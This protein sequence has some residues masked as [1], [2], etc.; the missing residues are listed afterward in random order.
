MWLS[1]SIYRLFMHSNGSVWIYF[2]NWQCHIVGLS[3]FLLLFFRPSSMFLW[4]VVRR[5]K[6]IKFYVFCSKRRRTNI[7][8][9]SNV[10]SQSPDIGRVVLSDLNNGSGPYHSSS[11]NGIPESKH[12]LCH[13]KFVC[14]G[15]S[16]PVKRCQ[17]V[18]ISDSPS[19]SSEFK[20]CPLNLYIKPTISLCGSVSWH[21]W[22]LSNIDTLQHESITLLYIAVH[23]RPTNNVLISVHQPYRHCVCVLFY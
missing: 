23:T 3:S 12:Y 15:N 22:L 2:S 10:E 14:E 17:L 4:N 19:L 5:V 7:N 20:V 1:I 9:N 16:K 18:D 8:M 11:C 13:C 21:E 6:N